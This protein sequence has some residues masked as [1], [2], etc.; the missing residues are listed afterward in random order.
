MI[1]LAVIIV[2]TGW[3]YT[4]EGEID[5]IQLKKWI[6]VGHKPMLLEGTEK[7]VFFRLK[8]PNEVATIKYAVIVAEGENDNS[9]EEI[10]ITGKILRYSFEKDGVIYGY[11]YDQSHDH[12]YKVMEEKVATTHPQKP[13]GI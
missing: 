2:S 12:Y 1:V 5:P 3:A 10:T 13:Q 7:A 11:R 8:N 4:Y 9:P 6:V